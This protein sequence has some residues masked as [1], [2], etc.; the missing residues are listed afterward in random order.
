MMQQ[1]D[2]ANWLRCSATDEEGF[3]CRLPPGHESAHDWQRCEWMEPDGT[4]CLMPPHH[5][6]P[7]QFFWYDRQARLGD[8]RTIRYSGNRVEVKSLADRGGRLAARRGWIEIGRRFERGLLWRIP[9]LSSALETLAD[10]GGAMVVD[11]SFR[12]SEPATVDG[13]EDASA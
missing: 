4:R 1:F 3:R 8:R 12:T 11:Y 7:H 13:P 10:P 6:G 9:I 2:M 5:P